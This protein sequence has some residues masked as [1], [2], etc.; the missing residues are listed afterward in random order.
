MFTEKWNL[1]SNIL[2]RSFRKKK[3]DTLSQD[4]TTFQFEVL[5]NTSTINKVI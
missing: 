5:C 4:K 2:K 1:N 3:S